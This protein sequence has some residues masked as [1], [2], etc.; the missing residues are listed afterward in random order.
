[1][2]FETPVLIVTIYFQDNITQNCA[3]LLSVLSQTN[4]LASDQTKGISE[5]VN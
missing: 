1:M 5:S 2:L 3:Y 4:I